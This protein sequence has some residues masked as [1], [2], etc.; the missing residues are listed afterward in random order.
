MFDR[1]NTKENLILRDIFYDKNNTG[2]KE[3]TKSSSYYNKAWKINRNIG[4]TIGTVRC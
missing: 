1:D 4:Q 2:T 3:A